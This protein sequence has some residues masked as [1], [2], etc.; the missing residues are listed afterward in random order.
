[1]LLYS[2]YKDVDRNRIFQPLISLQQDWEYSSSPQL[3]TEWHIYFTVVPM[4]DV[5]NKSCEI[6]NQIA[7]LPRLDMTQMNSNTSGPWLQIHMGTKIQVSIYKYE[8][9]ELSSFFF[10]KSGSMSFFKNF[11]AAIYTSASWINSSSFF[12]NGNTYEWD[13]V[14]H[15]SN[16]YMYFIWSVR[17]FCMC[18]RQLRWTVERISSSRPIH[19]L[20]DINHVYLIS[21]DFVASYK[22]KGSFPLQGIKCIHSTLF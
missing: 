15:I 17:M 10:S 2:L 22:T 16:I 21:G 4:R 20:N 7:R 19:R 12:M 8:V 3:L 1:M 9:V 5:Q 13:C 6:K 14:R 11:T 18:G